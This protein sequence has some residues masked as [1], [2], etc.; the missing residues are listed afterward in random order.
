[1][2]MKRHKSHT[3]PDATVS[4]SS[5]AHLHAVTTLAARCRTGYPLHTHVGYP[6]LAGANAHTHNVVVSFAASNLGSPNWWEHVHACT[7]VIQ[8]GGGSHAHNIGGYNSS[9]GCANCEEVGA[10][11][12]GLGTPT[13]GSGGA[14]HTHTY[15]AFNTGYADPAGTPEAHVHPFFVTLNIGDSHIHAVT[16]TIE[17]NVCALNYSHTH[18]YSGSSGTTN[19]N[20]TSSGNSGI[21]GEAPPPPAILMAGDGLVWI[22]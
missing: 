2:K 3:H 7:A 9:A 6:N 18:S 17:T 21:G 16:G 14:V 4:S 13:I 8:N 11:T 20:H 19:H 22:G 10:H 1:M 15:P 5:T 12:H